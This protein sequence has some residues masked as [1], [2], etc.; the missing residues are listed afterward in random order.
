MPLSS[1]SEAKQP[2]AGLGPAI[3]E[4]GYGCLYQ[5]PGRQAASS[6]QQ[7]QPHVARGTCAALSHLRTG[8]NA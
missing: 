8:E 7:E 1:S 5:E 6:Q 3:S 2:L 4:Q